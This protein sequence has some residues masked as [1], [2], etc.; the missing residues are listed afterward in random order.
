[1]AEEGGGLAYGLQ[2]DQSSANQGRGREAKGQR[3]MTERYKG[4]RKTLPLGKSR[5]GLSN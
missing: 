5:G 1:M 3:L 2:G 4:E